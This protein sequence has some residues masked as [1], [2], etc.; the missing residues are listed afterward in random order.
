MLEGDNRGENKV[1]QGLNA[2][3]AVEDAKS[4]DGTTSSLD[5]S[6]RLAYGILRIALERTE[7][8]NVLPHIH[9]WFV[10]P[11]YIT[12]SVSAM[13]LLENEFPWVGLVNMLNTLLAK[14]ECN[15]FEDGRFPVPG[16]GIGRPLPEDYSLRG[17]GWARTYFPDRWFEDVQVD[18]EKRSE[19]LPSTENTRI[20]RI[21][22]PAARIAVVSHPLVIP[23]LKRK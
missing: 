19:E 10:F 15:R 6:K 4:Q 5:F 22:R 17:L 12:C 2:L 13:L 23:F 16:K 18:D 14:Y 9:V 21:L 20:E 8:S 11:A 3:A 1:H 7:D